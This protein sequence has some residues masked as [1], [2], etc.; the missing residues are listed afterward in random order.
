MIRAVAILSLVSLL[1]LVLYVPSVHP[2]ERFMMQLRAEHAGAA[3]YWGDEPALRILERA[4][5]MQEMTTDATPVPSLKAAPSPA[6]VNGAVSQEMSTVNQRIF[7]NPY[8]RSVDALLLLASYRLSTLL[9][10]LPWLA[11]FVLAAI[12][13]GGFARLVKAKEFR[14]HD[15][16]IFALYASATI[17]LVC[18]TV[19]CF[20]LPV[21]LPPP[22]LPSFPLVVSVLAGRAV[23]CFHRR[24]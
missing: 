23:S 14:Q 19:I 17:A 13:D 9:E 21:T 11:A 4:V 5:R 10:Y 7:N 18:A 3:A 24:A 1:I 2:P 12:A 8:F 20:V 16:E 15:P 6:A 22:V